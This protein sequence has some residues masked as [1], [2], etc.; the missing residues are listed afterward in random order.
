VADFATEGSNQT[1]NDKLKINPIILTF[2]AMRIN[3]GNVSSSFFCTLLLV[4]VG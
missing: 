2:A 4:I 3:G 1:Y